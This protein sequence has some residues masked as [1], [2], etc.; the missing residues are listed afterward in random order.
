[1]LA[2]SRRQV[3][4]PRVVN[5][6]SVVSDISHMLQRMIGEDIELVTRLSEHLANTLLDPDQLGQVVFNLAVNARDAMPSGGVM[7]IETANVELDEAYAQAHPPL[8]SGSYVLLSVSDTGTG[9]SKAD[10]PRIF[11]PFFTTK[12]MG[13]G[14]GLGLAIVYGIVKQSGGYIWVYSEPGLGTTFKLYFPVAHSAVVLDASPSEVAGRPNGETILVV[15]DDAAIRKNVSD[16]LRQLGYTAL[17]AASGED[18]LRLCE[19]RQGAIDLML[20]DLVMP[21]MSGYTAAQRV[22]ERFPGTRVLYTSGYTAEGAA[23]REL[24]SEGANFLEKPYTVA[25][26]ARAVQR[27]LTVRRPDSRL[28]LENQA[29]S[30]AP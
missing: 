24:L 3:M 7:Q 9:I 26:L 8:Q 17:E 23:R 27:A 28:K 29:V 6:N 12:E 4:Q 20:T 14:T 30:V 5:I 22:S 1:M 19:Q 13:K 25:D 10:V 18:A 16:C 15:E 11:D 21:G 2:F